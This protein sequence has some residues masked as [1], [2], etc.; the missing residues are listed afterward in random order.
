MRYPAERI[1]RQIQWLQRRKINT[2]RLGLLRA[3]IEQD[4]AEPG[5]KLGSPNS[6]P[7]RPAGTDFGVALQQAKH[8]LLGNSI[9][10]QTP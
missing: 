6:S 1:E 8:R 4:W 2:N 7:N 9:N 5:G 10:H 3:A